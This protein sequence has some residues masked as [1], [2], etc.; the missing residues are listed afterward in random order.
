VQHLSE[1][2]DSCKQYLAL[3]GS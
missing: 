3:T 1:L 2:E